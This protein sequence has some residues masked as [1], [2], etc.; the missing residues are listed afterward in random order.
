MTPLRRLSPAVRTALP[1]LVVRG[2]VL[3]LAGALLLL[4]ASSSRAT[5]QGGPSILATTVKGIITPVV[6]DHLEEAI[7]RAEREGHGALLVQ[8]DTPGGLDT[9]MREIVQSF[10]N[11]RVPVIVYV[12]PP[13]ARAASAGAII[14]F[15]AHVAAM[16]PGTT[17]G[18]ATPIDL[19]GGDLARKVIND[20]AAY[21]ESI[22]DLR[23]RN[24]EFAIEAVREGRSVT[25]EDAVKIGAV[26]LLADDW[27]DLLA[28]ID[29]S[30][31]RVS[32][33]VDVTLRTAGA[34]IV[35]H[36]M[37]R[38][39]QLL[40]WLADPNIAF[41]FL[42]IGTL[43][44][45]Y[46]LANPG[47]GGAGIVGVILL[48]LGMFSLS[49]LPVNAAGLI[50]LA[51]A[52]VLFVAELFAPGIG[53]FAAGGTAALL[54]GGV[55]LFRGSVG[56]DTIVLLPTGLV[57]G[58]GT[59]LAGRIV[60]R[61]RRAPP[62]TGLAALLGRRAVVRTA[63]GMSGQVFLDG[64]WWNARTSGRPMEVGGTVRVTEVDGL[65]LVVEPDVELEE[66]TS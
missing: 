58:G 22:A 59:V 30:A 43:A 46:E 24:A 21:A 19:E 29:G 47:I 56:V 7:E 54:L 3:L 61:T 51:L 53:V 23:G 36:E 18:A 49:V 60:W 39:R 42:S 66:E 38:L 34:E 8:V 50:L 33:G 2:I 64:A 52:A 9:S 27:D 65:D 15:S 41:L 37:G 10:L 20:A 13:G 12:A 35:A 1:A 28:E 25:A 11:A 16:A 26:D 31:V 44:L 55:L 17:I 14:T 40:Q 45:L 4:G 5:A 62:T 57:V 6:A 63:G 32:P 48:I